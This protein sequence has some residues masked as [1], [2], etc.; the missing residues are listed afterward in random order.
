MSP[1]SAA[2]PPGTGVIQLARSSMWSGS[3]TCTRM[4][5]SAGSAFRRVIRLSNS[6]SVEE[7]GRSWLTDTNPHSCRSSRRMSAAMA[8]PSMI[9]AVMRS[10]P[11][12]S[13]AHSGMAPLEQTSAGSQAN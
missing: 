8:L 11:V 3:G 6:V 5:S 4:P 9:L 10:G 13:V 12:C 7:W 2:A 1:I